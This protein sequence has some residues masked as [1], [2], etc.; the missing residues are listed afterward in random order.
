MSTFG[1]AVINRYFKKFTL[2]W[3]SF[4]LVLLSFPVITYGVLQSTTVAVIGMVMVVVGFLIPPVAR[5]L[6]VGQ[7]EEEEEE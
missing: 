1:K 3:A 2:Q 7:E 5:Y 6:K 4:L